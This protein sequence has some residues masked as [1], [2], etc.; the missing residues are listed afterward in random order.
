MNARFDDNPAQA[1]ADEV[2]KRFVGMFGGEAVDRKYGAEPPQEWVAAISRLRDREIERGVRRLLFGGA[3]TVPSLPDF[4]R[5]CRSV[6]NDEF[7]DGRA[8]RPALPA[9]DPGPETDKWEVRANLDLLMPYIRR[10][11]NENP[12]RWGTP[13]SRLQAQ[14]TEILVRHK[15]RWVE[16][17]RDWGV[18]EK[19]EAEIPP[20]SEQNFVWRSL[21][22]QAEAEI[23]KLLEAKAA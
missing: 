14:A 5:L 21:M 3:R 8:D 15:N 23:A 7:E 4:M 11:L 19:G 16:H 6:S 9:P 10:R 20:A 2:W 12:R 1:R 18:D 22:E 17:M 13:G